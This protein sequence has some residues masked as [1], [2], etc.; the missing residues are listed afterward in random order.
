MIW[1]IGLINL[2]WVNAVLVSVLLLR[3]RDQKT[4]LYAALAALQHTRKEHRE[5]LAEIKARL[6][7]LEKRKA[8]LDPE[9]RCPWCSKDGPPVGRETALSG[10]G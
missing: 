6:N 10:S 7:Q 2:L 4:L 5:E 8:K 1:L 3:L 9:C